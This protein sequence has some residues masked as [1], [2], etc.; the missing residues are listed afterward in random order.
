MDGI[1]HN[2]AVATADTI[3]YSTVEG[4]GVSIEKPGL[5]QIGRRV[6]RLI[7]HNYKSYCLLQEL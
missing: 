5:M 2:A 6:K 4:S 1:L 7:F 3:S